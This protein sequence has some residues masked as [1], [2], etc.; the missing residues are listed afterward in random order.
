MRCK[1]AAL[2]HFSRIIGFSNI[3]MLQTMLSPRT[4]KFL[5]SLKEECLRRTY[6][7]LFISVL[8]RYCSTFTKRRIDLFSATSQNCLGMLFV[9]HAED[10]QKNRSEDAPKWGSTVLNAWR[11]YSSTPFACEY[12]HSVRMV[13]KVA[14]HEILALELESHLGKLSIDLQRE[15]TGQ[16]RVVTV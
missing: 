12:L 8:S 1:Y 11:A 6:S 15:R 5:T 3:F 4:L 13:E 7:W 2:L 10:V 14:R 9:T 16:Q